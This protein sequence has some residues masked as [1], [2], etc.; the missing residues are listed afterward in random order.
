MSILIG[1]LPILGSLIPFMIN[2]FLKRQ[3]KEN[4]PQQIL[5]EANEKTDTAIIN[6]DTTSLSILL[7]DR[8]S[9]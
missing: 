6:H 8:L 5:K 4:S 2:A 9:K 7:H 1:L 3:A